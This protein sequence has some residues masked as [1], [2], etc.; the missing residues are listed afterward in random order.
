M[1]DLTADDLIYK[2]LWVIEIKDRITAKKL[3]IEH[4]KK[5]REG[6]DHILKRKTETIREKQLKAELKELKIK[7]KIIDK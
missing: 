1:E 7:L 4:Y 5:V 2:R 3:V 6:K